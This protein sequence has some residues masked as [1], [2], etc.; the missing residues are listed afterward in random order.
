MF[1]VG[2]HHVEDIGVK[3]LEVQMSN[4]AGYAMPEICCLAYGGGDF[5]YLVR[6]VICYSREKHTFFI[7]I[8]AT[9]VY[10]PCKTAELGL[11]LLG[12]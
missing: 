12:G 10:D 11:K 5:Y 7:F 9:F 6:S 2:K 3:Q 1:G 4:G 8:F